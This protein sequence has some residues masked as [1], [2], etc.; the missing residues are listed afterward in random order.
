MDESTERPNLSVFLQVVFA[1]WRSRVTGIAFLPATVI[2]M[3]VVP[4][5]PKV[6]LVLGSVACA[7]CTAYQVW[8]KERKRVIELHGRPEVLLESVDIPIAANATRKAL[9]F[10]NPSA[11]PAM[12]ITI[13]NIRVEERDGNPIEI[14]FQPVSHLAKDAKTV[15]YAI[16][17]T[18]VLSRMDLLTCLKLDR[19]VT[20]YGTLRGTFQTTVEFSNYGNAKRWEIQ[21]ALE[22]DFTAGRIFCHP[23]TCRSLRA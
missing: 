3:F 7:L 9:Q 12:N 4:A 15:E 6:L 22:C 1:D 23:G 16:R 17:G 13:A 2:G 14:E 20:L 10:T 8:S 5:Y 18:G 21:Y 19:R 11:Y